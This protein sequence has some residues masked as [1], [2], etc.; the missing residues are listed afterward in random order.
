MHFLSPDKL[1]PRSHQVGFCYLPPA[2]NTD[3]TAPPIYNT[4]RLV[5]GAG[6]LPAG[7]SSLASMSSAPLYPYVVNTNY[8]PG[9]TIPQIP[10][11]RCVLPLLS[12]TA[13][14]LIC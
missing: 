1:R 7:I 13:S 3:C 12:D 10:Q 5:L 14:L 2:S 9:S 8:P 11:F 6:R 4:S